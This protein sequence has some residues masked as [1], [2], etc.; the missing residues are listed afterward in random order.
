MGKIK[1]K[2]HKLIPFFPFII[3]AIA[4]LVAVYHIKYYW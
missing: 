3:L 1:D 2:A 4:F